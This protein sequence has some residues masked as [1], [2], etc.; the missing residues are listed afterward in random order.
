MARGRNLPQGV[1]H[2]GK[3]ADNKIKKQESKL[4]ENKLNEKQAS[5]KLTDNTII[6][7]HIIIIIFPT[8]SLLCMFVL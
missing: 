5:R 7:W 4:R 1:E 6:L 3:I 8:S 2:K